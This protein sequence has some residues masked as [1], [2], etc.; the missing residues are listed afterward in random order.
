MTDAHR[1]VG[2]GGILITS[3]GSV[4]HGLGKGAGLVVVGARSQLVVVPG[5]G[6]TARLDMADAPA[7]ET[8]SAH[9]KTSQ[10]I[11]L[12]STQFHGS[13]TSLTSATP[14][15]TESQRHP[16]KTD[17]LVATPLRPRPNRL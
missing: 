16:A 11:R 14:S 9:F 3:R 12:V 15:T 8:G 1:D 7:D 2:T 6:A 10:G 13:A 5:C 4:E 17:Y